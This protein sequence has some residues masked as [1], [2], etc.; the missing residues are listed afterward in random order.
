MNRL[1]IGLEVSFNV[2][3]STNTFDDTIYRYHKMGK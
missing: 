2:T 3:D 1:I